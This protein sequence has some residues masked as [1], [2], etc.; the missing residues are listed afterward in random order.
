MISVIGDFW[1]N[2]QLKSRNNA[3]QVLF[4]RRP[5]PQKYVADKDDLRY[6]EQVQLD[7]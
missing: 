6:G 3:H 1:G 4:E 2:E 7:M 5:G